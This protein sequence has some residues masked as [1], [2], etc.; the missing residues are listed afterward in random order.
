MCVSVCLK[1]ARQQKQYKNFREMVGE[2]ILPSI[3]NIHNIN[4]Y[5]FVIISCN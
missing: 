2:I 5:L 4:L 1:G 3:V